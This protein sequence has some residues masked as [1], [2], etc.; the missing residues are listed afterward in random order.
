M[1]SPLLR[2]QDEITSVFDLLGRREVD[3]TASLGWVLSESP[4]LRAALWSRL[5]M[6][7]DPRGIEVSLESADAFGR[8]DLELRLGDEALVIVEAKKGWLQPGDGQLGKYVARF[9]G[10]GHGLFVSLSDSSVA[11]AARELPLHVGGVPVRHLPWDEVRADLSVCLAA[12]RKQAERGWLAELQ[13][14]L[15]GAT[16]VRTYDDQWVYVVSISNTMF[17]SMTFRDYVTKERV[18]FHPFGNYWPRRPPVLLG[19]RWN[20]R[21]QQVNR[22]TSSTVLPQLSQRWPAIPEVDSQGSEQ[23]PHVVYELGPD[24]RVPS[25][26]T[27]AGMRARRVWA[28][29]DQLLCEPT[30]AAAAKSSKALQLAKR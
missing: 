20:G 6:P 25:I 2:Y 5:E 14:Y 15:K 21:L 27:G 18:Y 11:W 9:A 16:A 3:L 12:S 10:V 26:P 4:A 17:G 22:A 13:T 7:G 23:G 24:L 28:L 29:L 19:F 1:T 30:I 8:T